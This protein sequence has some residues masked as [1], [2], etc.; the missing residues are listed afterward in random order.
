MAGP[1]RPGRWEETTD[2]DDVPDGRDDEVTRTDLPATRPSR[3]GP[4][5]DRVR[6]VGAEPAGEITGELPVVPRT[7]PTTATTAPTPERPSG[8]GEP[9]TS[10]R[11]A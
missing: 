3:T 10:P 9:S 6:I 4:A 1:V 11:S 8:G 2:V 5:T 7:S